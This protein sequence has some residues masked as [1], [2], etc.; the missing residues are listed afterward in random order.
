MMLTTY[1][2][3]LKGNV[4]SMD[5][6]K[7]VITGLGVVT[8]LGD[9]PKTFYKALMAGQSGITRWKNLEDDRCYCKIGGD[10]SDFNIIDYFSNHGDKY[11]TSVQNLSK[12]LFSSASPLRAATC[13]ASLQAFHDAGLGHTVEPERLG[14]IL[15][16]MNINTETSSDKSS[17]IPGEDYE[18][19]TAI[20]N[21]LNLTGPS[22]CV[23]GACASSN[24]AIVT[25]LDM[26]RSGDVDSVMITGA[27]HHLSPLILDAWSIMGA[28]SIQ[29]FN[30]QPERASR[31][32]DAKRE[33]F[34]PSHGSGAIVLEKLT[35]AKERGAFIYA[36]LLGAT[37]CMNASRLP[38][39]NLE[40][41]I[42]SMKQCLREAKINP[43]QIDY[44]NAH[45]TST[46]LGDMLEVHAIKQVFGDHA[47]K[48]P[49][50]ATKSMLGHSLS[51][52]G[53]TELIATLL[54]LQ[55]NTVHP[56]INQE[57]KDPEL[58]LN[59]VPNQGIDHRMNIALSNSFGFGG[60]NTSI[61]VKKH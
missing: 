38:K 48:I 17:L 41:G 43:D 46:P 49:I 12:E 33:G 4:M 29:S 55:H 56:T 15:A 16:G 3:V 25:G 23:G 30:D 19:L 61:I 53:I 1:S 22:F 13:I 14:H 59:F 34:I 32:F 40:G 52:A 31:P 26:I 42:Q 37:I 50:N 51:S 8:T 27:C 54:Q 7:V 57:E 9:D 21:L 5:Q 60:Y 20:N 18:I 2:K 28:L 45:G 6:Q 44:I 10:L 36:E 58:D 11:P 39:P 24:M 35:H 47:Y